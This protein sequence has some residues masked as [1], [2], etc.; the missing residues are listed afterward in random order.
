ML[1]F[2]QIKFNAM[3]FYFLRRVFKDQILSISTGH[4]AK[5]SRYDES[6]IIKILKKCSKN[7]S[8]FGSYLQL[9]NTESFYDNKKLRIDFLNNRKL[10][11]NLGG[12]AKRE[13]DLFKD[14]FYFKNIVQKNKIDLHGPTGKSD[15]NTGVHFN[16][17]LKID[18]ES[19]NSYLTFNNEFF[20]KNTS[21]ILRL[22]KSTQILVKSSKNARC[23]RKNGFTRVHVLCDL[24]HLFYNPYGMNMMQSIVYFL[25]N[26]KK[27]RPHLNGFDFYSSLDYLKSYNPDISYDEIYCGLKLHDA[28]VNY[29]FIRSLWCN[30][31]I[32]VDDEL[33]KILSQG[34]SRYLEHLDKIFQFEQC[35]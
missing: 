35:Q 34:L 30:N 27:K 18:P 32:T 31:Q 16:K 3:I 9:M 13:Q 11:I 20:Q 23:L 26:E 2:M 12:F 24:N 33:E 19:S 10:P 8:L 22:D 21:Q 1:T 4:R 25:I 14:T 17:I 15:E 28:C 5:K 7:I 6:F 29:A